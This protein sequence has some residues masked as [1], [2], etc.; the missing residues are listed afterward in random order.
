MCDW[1]KS[2]WYEIICIWIILLKNKLFDVYIW[3]Y[4]SKLYNVNFE[5]V[6]LKFMF[7]VMYFFIKWDFGIV[8]GLNFFF[9]FVLGYI[10][11]YIV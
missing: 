10:I 2:Y 6:V 4:C 1:C 8:S 11:K 7:I 9:F 5:I 3:N